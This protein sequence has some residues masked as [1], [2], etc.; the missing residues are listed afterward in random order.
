MSKPLRSAAAVALASASLCAATAFAEVRVAIE[1]NAPGI[2][3]AGFSFANLPPPS[4]HDAATAAGFELA[5][6]AQDRNG[7]R[8]DALH[9][10]RVPDAA[11]APRD[12]FFFRAGTDGG[13]LTV[14]LGAAIDIKQINTYSWHAGTRG[15]QVY[16]LYASDGTNAAFVARP[17]RGT[18][19]AACGWTRVAAVDTRPPQGD[20]G[21]QY[22]VGISDSQGAL[23]KYRHLLFD[24]SRTEDADAFGNTF[25]SEIDVVDLHAPAA[26]QPAAKP[27]REIVEAGPCRITID[28]TGTPDL[29]EWVHKELAPVV[30]EWYPRIA[31]LL[32]GEGFEA[33]R[34]VAI[35]FDKDMQGVAETG[36]ARIRCAAPWMRQNLQGEARGSIVHELVHVVQQYGSA[37]GPRPGWLV[38]GIA[39]YIRWFLYEPQSHGA[40]VR[41]GDRARY[42]AGYRVSAN[43]LHW[44]TGK[45]DKQLVAK[46]NAALRAGRYDEKL[47]QESTGHTVPELEA[48]WKQS[49]P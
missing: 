9:D 20:P 1:R 33:P 25:Y 37:R 17:R 7:S 28:T 47:W 4:A 13:R 32:P 35:V 31:A 48:E 12:N 3:T 30:Q 8:L 5:D 44:A 23:G 14:D 34:Q 19:P 39:D 11:D 46:L 42:N 22:G 29:T 10:G 41:K 38:E 2:A 27:L 40:D 26:P 15:P 45:Y 24:I 6:G 36:G 43:F 21:G 49:L 18:D 16:T